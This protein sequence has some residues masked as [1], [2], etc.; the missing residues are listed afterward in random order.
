MSVHQQGVGRRT[1]V[2]TRTSTR[3]RIEH[4]SEPLALEDGVA[5]SSA[6]QPV[7]DLDP[8]LSS[9]GA[10]VPAPSERDEG[11]V[12]GPVVAREEGD[13][14]AHEVFHS[15]GEDCE[16]SPTGRSYM[17]QVRCQLFQSTRPTRPERTG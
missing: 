17:R 10:E 15:D 2:H 7:M 11:Y 12:G 5:A 13:S 8:S 4:E 1:L 16:D 14:F 9:D 3:Q 6:E